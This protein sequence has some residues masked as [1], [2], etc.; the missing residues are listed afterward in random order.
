MPDKYANIIYDSVVESAANTLTFNSVDLGISLFDKVGLLISRIE[1]YEVHALLVAGDDTFYYGL[2]T[3]NQFSSPAP[4]QTS[5]ITFH[6]DQIYDYGVAGNNILHAEPYVD[7]FSTL[8]G[9]G[10]LVTPRPLYCFALGANL[11]SAGTAKFRM[12]FTITTLKAEEYF[13]LLESRQFF[14]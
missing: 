8:P 1:W 12:F 6:K 7:D 9:G 3:S 5:I 10:I 13:E 11:A 14:G 2:S 4:E